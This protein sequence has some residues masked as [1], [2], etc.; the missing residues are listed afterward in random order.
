[1]KNCLIEQLNVQEGISTKWLDIYR[2]FSD[3]TPNK[4]IKFFNAIKDLF[5]ESKA[6]RFQGVAT[7]FLDTSLSRTH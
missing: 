4:Q 5:P 3:L 2:D 6:D 7:K 1:M